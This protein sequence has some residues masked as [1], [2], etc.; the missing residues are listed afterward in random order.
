MRLSSDLRR[1]FKRGVLVLLPALPVAF[2]AF[3]GSLAANL[4]ASMPSNVYLVLDPFPKFPGLV[5]AFS[6]P[7]G[8]NPEL[9]FI[10][11]IAGV[12]GDVVGVDEDKRE[13]SING[14]VVAWA[15]PFT[16]GGDRLEMIE[17]GVIPPDHFFML[18]DLDPSFDSRFAWVGLIHRDRIYGAGF[19]VPFAPSARKSDYETEGDDT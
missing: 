15:K 11:R 8:F 16:S 9:A 4:T 6:P 1:R 14:H 2:I 5:A 7:Q 19:G 13:V 17:P 10:K 18:G 3:C 12:P